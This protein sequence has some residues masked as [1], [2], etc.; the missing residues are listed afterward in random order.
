MQ[1]RFFGAA[2]ALL[3]VAVGCSASAD[4]A[5]EQGIE[6]SME[7]ASPDGEDLSESS[8]NMVKGRVIWR[9]QGIEIYEAYNEYKSSCCTNRGKDSQAACFKSTYSDNR[10]GY[11]AQYWCT[12]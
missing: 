6:Q 12:H 9:W 10:N 1:M 2:A 5:I 11:A 7:G 8:N 3:F 4:P